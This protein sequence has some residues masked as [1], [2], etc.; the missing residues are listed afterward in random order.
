VIQDLV[1]NSSLTLNDCIIFK[2]VRP[3]TTGPECPL[4]EQIEDTQ[5]MRK[6]RDHSLGEYKVSDIL[7]A[8]HTESK[9]VMDCYIFIGENKKLSKHS[10]FI[11][12]LRTEMWF[13]NY[14]FSTECVSKLRNRE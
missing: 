5:T 8:I 6:L 9:N 10:S 13:M 11:C 7:I 12:K 14:D 1:K 4:C 2:N 3:W